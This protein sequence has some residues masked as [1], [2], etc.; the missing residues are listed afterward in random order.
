[1]ITL[2]A[3]VG[4]AEL[5]VGNPAVAL[6]MLEPTDS[7]MDAALVRTANADAAAA[8]GDRVGAR[9]HREAAIALYEAKNSPVAVA[10]QRELL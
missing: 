2:V 6:A 8:L 4:S 5:A 9:R 7:L 1:M 10:R 3:T